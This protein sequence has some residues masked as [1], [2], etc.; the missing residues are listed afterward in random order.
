MVMNALNYKLVRDL[1]KLRGQ[2]LA[3]SLVVACGIAIFIAMMSTYQS[4]ATSQISY[5]QQYRFAQVFTQLK[6]APEPLAE[7]IRSIPGVAQVQTRVVVNVTLD[8]PG[9]KEPAIGRL[10]SVPETRAPILNDVYL[11][12]GRYIEPGRADEVLVSE[13]FATANHLPLGAKIG[14]IING[15]W[16]QLTIVGIALSPEYVYEIRS[17]DF[18]PDNQR[19]G[20]IWIGRKALGTAFNLDGALAIGMS[21]GIS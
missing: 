7:R 8:V 10:V 18:I 2:V 5:Y 16:Q 21:V 20:V 11:R 1:W 13:T 3:I 19:F 17:G 15:R 4:L 14:A 9:R 12:Q 6:R